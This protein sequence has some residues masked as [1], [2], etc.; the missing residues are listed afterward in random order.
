MQKVLEAP[1]EAARF[2]LKTLP[3]AMVASHLLPIASLSLCP[4]L[5]SAPFFLLFYLCSCSFPLS[6]ILT[7]I[8]RVKA[9]GAKPSDSLHE[10]E[11]NNSEC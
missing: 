9:W 11:N 1:A 3:A 6:L 5:A 8:P 2:H 7:T 4:F 10:K